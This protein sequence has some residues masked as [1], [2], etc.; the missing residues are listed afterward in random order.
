MPDYVPA[1]GRFLPVS[2][3]DRS[4]SVTMREDRW[5]PLVAQLAC[6]PG[7]V[8]EVG[9]G[10]GSQALELARVCE[11]VV[12]VDPDDDALAIARDKQGAD[13]VEWRAGMADALPVEYG[14][15][16][17]VVMTL[18]L[19]H[20]DPGGKRAALREAHRVLGPGGRLVIADWGRPGGPIPALAFRGLMVIDGAAGTADHAAGRLP[21]YVTGAGFEPPRV[22]LRVP[23]AWG[24][25]EVMHAARPA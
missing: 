4:V 2:I 5:R 3:F 25:L 19:H 22:R 15:A 6:G 24:T 20:L 13:A 12:A 17:A 1:A 10:T 11:R 23:T 16:S 8:V 9:A 21:E 14:A 18:L 7:L